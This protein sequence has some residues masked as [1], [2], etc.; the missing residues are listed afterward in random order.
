MR[1]EELTFSQGGLDP[2]SRKRVVHGCTRVF[3]HGRPS[4]DW[5]IRGGA[6][7][8]VSLQSSTQQRAQRRT[9]AGS[10]RSHVTMVV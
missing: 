4:E 1:D 3:E 8:R 6:A 2:V 5:T 10:P 7:R 9:V